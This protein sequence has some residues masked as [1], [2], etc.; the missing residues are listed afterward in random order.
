MS[1]LDRDMIDVDDG[2]ARQYG[3][4]RS[5]GELAQMERVVDA[6]DRMATLARGVDWSALALA[7]DP[8]KRLVVGGVFVCIHDRGHDGPCRLPVHMRPLS[9]VQFSDYQAMART[10]NDGALTFESWGKLAIVN[11]VVAAALD[12]AEREELFGK[13]SGVFRCRACLD[14]GDLSARFDW[15][16]ALFIHLLGCSR[17][18]GTINGA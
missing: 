2:I 3:N 14:A 8:C 16:G 17:F 5:P 18:T 9:A 12:A 13:V 4:A 1:E 11:P 6:V 15:G 7:T 10:L